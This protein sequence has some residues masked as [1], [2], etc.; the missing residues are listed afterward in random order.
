[1]CGF[2]YVCNT[3]DTN[4][5]ADFLKLS[6]RFSMILT[7]VPMA[8]NYITGLAMVLLLIQLYYMRTSRQISRLSR[9][10]KVPLNTQFTESGHG[11][12]HI[13]AL[14][15]QSQYT[16]KAFEAI[17][18]SQKLLYYTF[19]IEGWLVVVT[20]TMT[21]LIGLGIL[22]IV[23]FGELSVPVSGIALSMVCL[24]SL[25]DNL[26][27]FLKHWAMLEESI[28]SLTRVKDFIATTPQEVD[29]KDQIILPESW[30]QEGKVVL[31][32]VTAR[33]K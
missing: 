4:R 28:S 10:S 17:D 13:R 6:M 8:K 15:W 29:P 20:D 24:V 27:Q 7:A 16:D 18:S 9:E 26:M 1:M 25:S 33:H 5:L 19:A 3:F 2:V 32:N 21:S 23:L 31:K 22:A 12:Q 30:P 14:N 11:V